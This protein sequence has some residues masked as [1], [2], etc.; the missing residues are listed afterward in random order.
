MAQRRQH[1]ALHDLDTHFRL[2]LVPGFAHPC[3][4]H[5]HP[6]VRRQLQVG[7]IDVRLV[8]MG[9]AHPARQIIGNQNR[10]DRAE[11]GEGAHMCANP[12][13][14]PLGPGGLDIGVVRGAEYRHEDLGLTHLT[15]GAIN[16]RHRLPGIVDEQLLPG[17]MRLAHHHVERAAPLLVVLAEPAV[18]EARGVR[19]PVLLPQQ[20]QRHARAAEFLM[21]LGPVRYHPAV[22]RHRRGGRKQPLLQLR[23]AHPLGQRPVQPGLGKTAQIV[24]H[25]A[26][27]HLQADRHLPLRQTR[28]QP[29]A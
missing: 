14:Q 11:V 16:H 22:A 20:H 4:D 28:L 3:R 5:G 19:G 18:T 21:H 15:A 1:P 27:R 25:A 8:A 2:G 12:V 10:R 23:V 13:G 17:G 29:Q 6:V 7:G 24:P 9:L 26:A